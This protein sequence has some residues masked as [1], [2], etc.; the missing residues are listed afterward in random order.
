[1][2][3]A[4]TRANPQHPSLLQRSGDPPPPAEYFPA[5]PLRPSGSPRAGFS[6]P[7]P[8]H[9]PAHVTAE[10][11]CRCSSWI[12]GKESAPSRF[13]VDERAV[14]AV[15][16]V[17]STRPLSPGINALWPLEASDERETALT[18]EGL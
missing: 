4:R 17:C 14:V 3:C 18:A 7:V 12:A 13:L 6:L 5:G 15:W 11:L 1:M 2:C 8:Y 16:A 10:Q 9:V